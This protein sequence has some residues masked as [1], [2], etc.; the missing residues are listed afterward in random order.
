MTT[1][2]DTKE[3]A[4]ATRAPA[5]FFDNLVGVDVAHAANLP[6]TVLAGRL[7]ADRSATEVAVTT[8]Y[9]RRLGLREAQA[10][11][12]VGTEISTARHASSRI[13][14]ATPCTGIGH[15][16]D[17]VGVVAQEAGSGRCSPRSNR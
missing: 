4:A 1:S 15:M 12:V 7:P 3:K 9:L 14:A 11:A 10:A 16:A 13:S 5:Q 6:V 17:I 8:S 2:A